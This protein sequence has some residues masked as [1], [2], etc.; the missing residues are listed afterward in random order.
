MGIGVAKQGSVRPCLIQQGRNVRVAPRAVCE[1][2]PNFGPGALP[3]TKLGRGRERPVFRW[4]EAV[5][6]AAR[7]DEGV[8]LRSAEAGDGGIWPVKPLQ[9]GTRAVG[10]DK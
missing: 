6:G 5:G 8:P 3:G 2:S 10:D 4:V 1:P 9:Q 7:L